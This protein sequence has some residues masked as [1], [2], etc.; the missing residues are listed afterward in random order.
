MSWDSA[1]VDSV[2]TW[3]LEFGPQN[4]HCTVPEKSEKDGQRDSHLVFFLSTGSWL[5][6]QLAHS[7]KNNKEKSLFSIPLV[8][9]EPTFPHCPCFDVG[10]MT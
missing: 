3:R 4:T 5:L 2:C 6:R 9:L 10:P 1:F 8:G 7:T